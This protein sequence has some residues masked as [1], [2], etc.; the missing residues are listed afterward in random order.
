MLLNTLPSFLQV[1]MAFAGALNYDI[2]RRNPSASKI[3]DSVD[4]TPVGAAASK[5]EELATKKS[6]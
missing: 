1:W 3:D 4:L 6:K 5:V 2:Y